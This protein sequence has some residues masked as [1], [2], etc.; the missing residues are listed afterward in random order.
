MLRT[1]SYLVGLMLLVMVWLHFQHR[2]AALATSA[3]TSFTPAV[4]TLSGVISA[5]RYQVLVLDHIGSLHG[6]G[7]LDL[8]DVKKTSLP[9][10]IPTTGD[11]R[12]IHAGS[13][14]VYG[15]DSDK[16]LWRW[17]LG[18]SNRREDGGM[19]SDTP[20]RQV[21]GERQW[22]KVEEHWRLGV[23]VDGL[24]KLW[25]WAEEAYDWT[26]PV[27][28][29]NGAPR[30]FPAGDGGLDWRDICVG[31]GMFYAVDSHGGLWRS[32][33]PKDSFKHILAKDERDGGVMPDRLPLT[34]IKADTRFSRV[35]CRENTY[36]VLALDEDHYLWGFGST[37]FGE[38]GTGERNLKIAETGIRRL[39][40][41]QWLEI[42]I[43]P[44]TTYGIQADGSLWAWG[45]NGAVDGK[46]H[47]APSLVDNSRSWIAI[48]A[49]YRNAAALTEDGKLHTWG[50]NIEGVLG[51]GDYPESRTLP[52]VVESDI[53]WKSGGK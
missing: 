24:D 47:Y 3:Q 44:Q 39:N 15:I 17:S 48:A 9:H 2:P 10:A 12:Y 50:E 4:Q 19:R 34:Q 14:T 26:D 46:S 32:N 35:F 22:R 41:M 37:S 16:H 11:W 33:L 25:V 43:A 18:G 42:A 31:Q 29:E 20:F 53:S 38:L 13:Y 40:E 51:T 23:G 30:L 36:H 6:W 49:G 1:M 45:Q 8:P 52:A 7:K 28:Q 21:F 5:G 27:L